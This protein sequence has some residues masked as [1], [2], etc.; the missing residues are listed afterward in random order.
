MAKSWA[1]NSHPFA[2]SVLPD[3]LKE[4]S[5]SIGALLASDSHFRGQPRL[6]RPRLLL[7]KPEN[8]AQDGSLV[9]H[10]PAFTRR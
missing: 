7:D 10:N 1:L 8:L 5:Y 9:V 2:N 4:L 3:L 6:E